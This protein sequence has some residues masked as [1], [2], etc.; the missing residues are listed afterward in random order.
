M[1]AGLPLA[2]VAGEAFDFLG[3]VAFVPVLQDP[4]LCLPVLFPGPGLLLE[5]LRPTR[6]AGIGKARLEVISTG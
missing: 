1:K 3:Q 4:F 5:F 2:G 6:A